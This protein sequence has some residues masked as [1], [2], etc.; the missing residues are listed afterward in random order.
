MAWDG[1]PANYSDT[2][3]AHACVLD[4]GPDAGPPKQRYGLPV[5]DPSGA[6]NCD[7]VAAARRMIGQVT[8]ASPEALA[9]AKAKLDT[10]AAQCEKQSAGQGQQQSGQGQQASGQQASGQAQSESRS[11]PV[12][13]EVETR[14]APGELTVEGRRLRGVVPYNIES[15]DLGGWRER[16]APGCLRNAQLGDLVATVDHSG[17]PIGRYPGT[18]TLEDRDDGLHWSVELPESRADVREAVERGDLN[19]S[20]WRMIVAR[21]RWDGDV[22]TVEEV[23]ALRD[24]AVVVNPA[25]PAAQ[26]ELRAA[27]EPQPDPEEAVMPEENER[28]GGLTVESRNAPESRPGAGGAGDIESRVLEAIRSVKPGESRSLTTTSASPIDTPELSTYIFDR[29]RPNSVMLASGIKV[30]TTSRESIYFPRTITDVAPDWT[31]ETE[32]LPESDPGW[33]QLQITPSKLGSRILASNESLDDAPVDLT[34]WLQNHLLKLIGLKLDLA[35]IEGN[36]IGGA[37]GI[38]GLKYQS[39]TQTVHQAADTGDGAELTDLDA[40]AHA[41]GLIEE[42]NATASAIVMHPAVWTQA[43]LMK[44]RNERY[45]LSPAQDPTQKPAR[46]LFGV[47]VYTTS[48]LSQTETRG[49]ATATSSIYVYDSSQVVLVRRADVQVEV[50]RYQFF[51]TDQTQIRAKLRVGFVLPHPAA[52]VRIPGIVPVTT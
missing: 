29:L 36:P 30:M 50:D 6:L 2:E 24:V 38:K 31:P 37:P 34:G 21:D 14:S 15:R 16:M 48:A 12:A 11:R 52:V 35:L 28:A 10:L 41:I 44:D 45:L 46:S 1:S 49:T 47:P 42:A 26:A 43:A 17:L 5:R 4:R 8:G 20:S 51:S 9:A 13:G 22:R 40:I 3:Y 23:R 32:E 39:D 33:D 7:G 18:L 25:Y 27:P 19:A